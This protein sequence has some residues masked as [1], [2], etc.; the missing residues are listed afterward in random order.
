MMR[1][2]IAPK[3]RCANNR[4]NFVT[5][6]PSQLALR[7]LRAEMTDLRCIAVL[8]GIGILLGISGPFNTIEVL[9]FI[10]RLIYWVTVAVTTYATGTFVNV[11][12]RTRW[13]KLMTNTIT[14]IAA[15]GLATGCAVF[16][17]LSAITYAA[18]GWVY[19]SNYEVF[20]NFGLICLICVIIV[21]LLDFARPAASGSASEAQIT[22]AILDRLPLEKRGP[23]I[24]ISVRD[25]YV[26]VVTAKGTEM[27]LLRLSDAI[28]EIAPIEGLQ[29]H[30]SHWV[31][32]GQVTA[33]IRKGDR[34]ILTMSNGS[35]I[36][37]SR[38]YVPALKAAGLLPRANN[39]G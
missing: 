31:A 15:L 29:V 28:R 11:Y 34:A 9:A 7:D 8:I 21:W 12:G 5:D 19:D 39:N 4:D 37:V 24:S 16:V 18:F 20:E 23:L 38:T 1:R 2:P 36:P 13:P 26:D 14:R 3:P 6:L 17:V 33:A 22:P 27:L 35:D 30:R 32:K 25:H 10:P